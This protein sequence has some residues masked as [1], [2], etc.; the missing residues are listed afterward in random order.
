[1]GD[2][3]KDAYKEENNYLRAKVAELEAALSDAKEL[4]T[5]LKSAGLEPPMKR[6]A[7]RDRLTAELHKFKDEAEA[8]LAER[9]R[10]RGDL[11][12]ADAEL[13][14]LR[15]D[16]EELIN[17]LGEAEAAFHEQDSPGSEEGY[18]R[19]LCVLMALSAVDKFV[20]KR[21]ADQLLRMPLYKLKCALERDD[22][23]LNRK[24][25]P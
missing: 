19:R 22:F 3:S 12:A 7:E 25:I 10:M 17:S 9:N 23:S 6:A 8:R 13:Q 4:N 24:W 18:N 11:N 21:G 15:D 20:M 14:K 5:R 1:M 16:T 2:D